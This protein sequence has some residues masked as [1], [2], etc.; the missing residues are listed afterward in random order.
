MSHPYKQKFV[1]GSVTCDNNAMGG[2]PAHGYHKHCFCDKHCLWRLSNW[3]TQ[4]DTTD[5]RNSRLTVKVEKTG[6]SNSRQEIVLA[7]RIKRKTVAL[8]ERKQLWI[9]SYDLPPGDWEVEYKSGGQLCQGPEPLQNVHCSEGFFGKDGNCTK[10]AI[11]TCGIVEVDQAAGDT[12]STNGVLQISISR[13]DTTPQLLLAPINANQL[14]TVTDYKY[15]R[16]TSASASCREQGHSLI[17]SATECETAA[18]MLKLKVTTVTV[19]HTSNARP[20]GCFLYTG[21]KPSNLE[22]NRDALPSKWAGGWSDIFTICRQ[23]SGGSGDPALSLQHP[24]SSLHSSIARSPHR[25]V[26]PIPR[27]P[28]VVNVLHSMLP[29]QDGPI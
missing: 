18:R 12:G 13:T 27:V 11:S 3:L 15:S 1:Q 24:S 14:L 2:D 28:G 4:T 16:S 17:A 25:S 20:A 22:F 21:A 26:R 7:S 5:T 19:V 9:A 23:R 6:S 29:K 8:A 10:E